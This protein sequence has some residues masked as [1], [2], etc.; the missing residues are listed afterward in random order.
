MIREMKTRKFLVNIIIWLPLVELKGIKVADESYILKDD[1]VPE[2][3]EFIFRITLLFS[4]GR[5][6]TAPS[7]SRSCFVFK[8]VR[9]FKIT[10]N[11]FLGSAFMRRTSS[12]ST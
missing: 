5:N 12:F 7:N 8:P 3:D 2:I 4:D 9:A 10:P 1:E 11:G 6:P